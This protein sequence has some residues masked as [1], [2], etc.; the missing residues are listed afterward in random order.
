M[1]INKFPPSVRFNTDV[2]GETCGYKSQSEQSRGR[3]EIDTYHGFVVVVCFVVFLF[4]FCFVLIQKSK[5]P[6]FVKSFKSPAPA[7]RTLLLLLCFF[8]N[9]AGNFSVNLSCCIYLAG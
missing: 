8:I 4:L 5:V 2:N 7:V 3:E 1:H 9:A 6:Q